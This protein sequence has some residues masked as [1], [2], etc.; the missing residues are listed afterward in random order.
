M[1]TPGGDGDRGLA[2]LLRYVA[3]VRDRTLAGIRQKA[4]GEAQVLVRAARA[5]AG[6][7]IRHALR[8]A[9][10]DA[11][12]RIGLARAQAQARTRRARHALTLLAL[13]KIWAR[14]ETALRER[15]ND[16]VARQAWVEQALAHAGDH[17]PAGR[18]C[19]AHPAA[20]NPEECR[21]A[22]D[23]LRARRSGVTLTFESA[24]LAAGVR[25]RCESAEL[26]M[27]V[28]G[29]L[30]DRARI[31]GAWLAELERASKKGSDPFSREKLDDGRLKMDPTPFFGTG[32]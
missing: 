9:R 3:D 28:A 2:A 22:F 10:Q 1:S 27:T 20:W 13:Q 26:D 30:R 32:T 16:G 23:A 14:L 18:W 12:A 25:V 11:D 8:E 15:W 24:A 19:V 17:L 21:S 31:E 4:A 6:E 7:Q 5:R 29:L